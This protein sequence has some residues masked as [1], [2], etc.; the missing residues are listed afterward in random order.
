MPSLR[1]LRSETDRVM[2]YSPKLDK[3][4]KNNWKKMDKKASSMARRWGIPPPPKT[5]TGAG[6]FRNMRKIEND[7]E[8][9]KE[10]TEKMLKFGKMNRLEKRKRE[11]KE[12]QV[13]NDVKPWED[14]PKICFKQPS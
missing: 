7:V 4:T 10:R 6:L 3:E 1:F 11:T 2:R 12:S 13:D 9:L 14:L 8:S 5:E